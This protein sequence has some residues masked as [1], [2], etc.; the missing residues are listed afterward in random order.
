MKDHRLW[1]RNKGVSLQ[2]W[3]NSSIPELILL[4]HPFS[5]HNS[6]P[7]TSY[8]NLS[9][10]QEVW[11][12][13]CRRGKQALITTFLWGPHS[14][15]FFCLHDPLAKEIPHTYSFVVYH[16]HKFTSLLS[17]SNIP[18]NSSNIGGCFRGPRQLNS[19]LSQNKTSRKKNKDIEFSLSLLAS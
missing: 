14:H 6:H 4:L 16:Q 1:V 7:F 10:P 2:G 5:V 18:K 13:S 3:A 9:L 12:F 11:R 19:H 8:I 15:S 17:T